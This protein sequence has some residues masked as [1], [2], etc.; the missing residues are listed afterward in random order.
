MCYG[1]LCDYGSLYI[2]SSLR[3]SVSVYLF[4]TCLRL[5][6]YSSLWD[7]VSMSLFVSMAPLVFMFVY[8]SLSAFNYPSDAV[9]QSLNQTKLDV[10]SDR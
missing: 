8:L 5:Y 2:N 9:V 6:L 4:V 1:Y 7:Y 10:S 3:A